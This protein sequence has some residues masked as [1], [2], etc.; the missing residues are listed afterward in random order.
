MIT[1]LS[2]DNWFALDEALADIVSEFITEHSD[3]AVEKLEAEEASF[4]HI[5]EALV[6]LPFLTSKKLIILKEATHSKEFTEQFNELIKEI[7]D[8]TDL[9]IVERHIDKRL[10]VYKS[11]KSQ[12]NYQEFNK[13]DYPSL[14][15]WIVKTVKNRQGSISSV[16]AR[17]LI[18]RLGQDQILLSNEIDKLLLYDPVI[19]NET[20]ELL[21]ENNPQSTIFQ[22]VESAFKGQPKQT[23]SLYKEQRELKEEPQK[24][25]SML[26]WQLHVLT[27][28]KSGKDKSFDQIIKEAK[29]NPFVARKSQS[30][31]SSV[32]LIDLKR[33][34]SQLLQV[35]LRSKQEKLDLDEALENYLLNLSL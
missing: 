29:I 30:L 27:I 24:I 3:L 15:D 20:I 25:M 31:A 19:T 1:T 6:S 18:E 12:T 26:V 21:T 17:Y 14:I 4:S 34:I 7:P 16:G 9:V 22:L 28:I 23:L 33:H 5:K 2:G 10:S 35:D 11:L 8:T 32:D 13:L